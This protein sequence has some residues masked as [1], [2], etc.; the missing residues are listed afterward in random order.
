M[1]ARVTLPVALTPLVHG[2]CGPQY[3]VFKSEANPGGV[4]L[5]RSLL[6]CRRSILAGNLCHVVELR[7]SL[8]LHSPLV[9]EGNTT[10]YVLTEISCF[11]RSR[12]SLIVAPVSRIRKGPSTT[13]RLKRHVPV[14][15]G[16]FLQLINLS[17][18]RGEVMT[19]TGKAP[20]GGKGVLPSVILTHCNA[21]ETTDISPRCVRQGCIR[22]SFGPTKSSRPPL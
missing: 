21:R 18:R 20:H 11:D 1:L 8:R 22:S 7:T 6:P 19:F 15:K 13:P 17:C 4:H 14:K 2:K 10:T 9:M 3:S 5:T 16:V 12:P